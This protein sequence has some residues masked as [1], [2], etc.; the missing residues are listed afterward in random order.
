MEGII[1]AV[2]KYKYM[3]QQSVFWVDINTVRPNQYQ[4]RREFNE[5]SL[6]DLANSIRQYGILQPLVVV[7]HEDIDDLGN[8]QTHYE[9]IAG[10]RRLRASKKVGLS[11]VP[12]I[13]KEGEN[14]S[15]LKLELAIIENVQREDLNPIDKAI[16]FTQLSEEFGLT[17]SEIAEKVGKS[18]EYV[19]NAM[20]LVSLPEEIKQS[21]Q[22]GDLT[23][24]HARVLLS[25]HSKQEQN[26]LFQDII[27]K[28]L[29]VR[30]SETYARNVSNSSI[31]KE[32]KVNTR[33]RD[34][35]MKLEETLGTRVHIEDRRNKK[36]INIDVYS[37]DQIE[38]LLNKLLHKTSEEKD[39][40][41]KDKEVDTINRKK[42][43]DDP[44]SDFSNFSI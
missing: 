1:N 42:D 19:S 3:E 28:K 20:R 30:E 16:A 14:T 13:I 44:Y 36:Q 9:L 17:H 15:Q 41:E 12:V 35:E 25:L 7:K 4:P 40:D 27:Q 43:E 34:L 37:E 5:N 24:G 38:D 23:E 26:T 8:M 22:K 11:H 33:I 39:V 32:L 6:N 18:R 31:K 21:I 29:T 2:I 10:E